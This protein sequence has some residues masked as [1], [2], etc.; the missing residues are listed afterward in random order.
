MSKAEAAS[1][2]KIIAEHSGDHRSLWQAFNEILHR[3]PKLHLPDH[4]SIEAF[5]NNF[6]SFLINKISIIR[7]SFPPGSCSN[8]LTPSNTREVLHN[9]THVADDEMR[10]FVLSAPCKS[11]DLD[12]IPTSLSK[13][14]IDILVTPIVSIVNLTLSEG[15]LP[16]H[17]KS[18]LVFPLL[19]KPT[20]DKDVMTNYRPVSHLSF[21]SKILEQVV[22]SHLN[23]HVNSLQ[24]STHYQSAYRKFHSIETALLKMYNDILSAL[25]DCKVTALTLL[26]LSASFDTIGHTILLRRLNDWVGVSG[27]VLD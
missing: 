26:D 14:C 11:S 24:I 13:D 4:S 8:A 6:S 23:L 19:K 18:V 2:P 27:K 10:R 9:L 20:L 16:S 21:P 5:T 22:A 17:F 15:C 7:S 1:F 25:D 3:C 12:P